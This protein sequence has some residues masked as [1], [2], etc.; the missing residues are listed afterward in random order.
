MAKAIAGEAGDS[1]KKGAKSVAS[2]AHHA[3]THPG[4]TA[5]KVGKGLANTAGDI[6]HHALSGKSFR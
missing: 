4:E 3:V 2:S 1:L 6:A 5:K